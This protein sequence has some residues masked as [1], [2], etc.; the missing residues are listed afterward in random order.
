MKFLVYVEGGSDPDNKP[1]IFDTI[2]A[3]REFVAEI[4]R[5]VLTFREQ[6]QDYALR[7]AVQA[8]DSER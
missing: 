4:T 7:F 2:A 8:A 3:A 6:P 1:R 5:D